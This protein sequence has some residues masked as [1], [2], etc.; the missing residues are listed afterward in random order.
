M[1][2][3]LNIATVV[4]GFLLLLGTWWILQGTGLVPIGYMANKIEYAYQG[5]V[6]DLVGAGLLFFVTWFRRRN[7]PAG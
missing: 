6:V 1:K 7:P 5:L 2:W 4:G 3:M